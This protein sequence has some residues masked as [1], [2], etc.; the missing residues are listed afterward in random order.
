MDRVQVQP[1]PM[2]VDVVPIPVAQAP[3]GGFVQM[4]F[5]TPMGVLAFFVPAEAS[6]E[7]RAEM[8]EAER[9]VGSGLIVPPNGSK[10]VRPIRDDPRA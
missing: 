9:Q 10:I 5:S 8:L 2:Q 1:V 7:L 3:G 4:V 6:K